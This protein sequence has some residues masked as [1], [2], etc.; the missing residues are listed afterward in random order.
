MVRHTG[1]G[2]RFFDYDY[3]HE[4][5]SGDLGAKEVRKNRKSSNSFRTYVVRGEILS[6]ALG[7]RAGSGTVMGVGFGDDVVERNV[8]WFRLE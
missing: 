7:A 5:K 4:H 1:A 2:M 6:R 8:V 3:A